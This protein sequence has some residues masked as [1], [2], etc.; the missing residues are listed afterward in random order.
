[1]YC[2]LFCV[3]TR[4][5]VR[6]MPVETKLKALSFIFSFLSPL[7]K[8]LIILTETKQEVEWAVATTTTSVLVE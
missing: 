2:Y 1:M 6:I 7:A 8:D 5:L 4:L 3:N